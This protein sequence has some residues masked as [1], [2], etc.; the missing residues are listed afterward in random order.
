MSYLLCLWLKS[1]YGGIVYNQDKKIR[2]GEIKK[3]GRL[4]KV[5][6]ASYREAVSFTHPTGENIIHL[7][8]R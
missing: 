7:K 4:N 1:I 8:N 3:G 5:A 2:T 6:V